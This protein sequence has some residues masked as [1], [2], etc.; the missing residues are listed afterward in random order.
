MK[1]FKIVDFYGGEFN[2][3]INGS[4]KFKSVVGGILS[5]ITVSILM[6]V[7]FDLGSDFIYRTNPYI[8][9]DDNLFV[10]FS[11]IT[12]ADYPNK[13]IFFEAPKY[14]KKLAVLWAFQTN[15][16]ESKTQILKLC[17]KDYLINNLKFY[18]ETEWEDN[19]NIYDFY[20]FNLNEFEIPTIVLGNNKPVTDITIMA[21]SCKDIESGYSM[22]SGHNM[23][24]TYCEKDSYNQ[25]IDYTFLTIYF[26]KLGFSA[27]ADDPFISKW[28][29]IGFI[30]NNDE[31]GDIKVPVNFYKLVDDRGWL[32]NNIKISNNLDFSN[33]R[34][35]TSKIQT[36]FDF[37]RFK[38][39]FSLSE[40]YKV[41]SRSYTKL[42]DFLAKIGGFMKLVLT[43]LSILNSIVSMYLIDDHI[44]EK[45][46]IK[47][48]LTDLRNEMRHKLKDEL[49]NTNLKFNNYFE[50]RNLI[51]QSGIENRIKLII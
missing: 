14:L 37:P 42:P 9:T 10:N 34:D 27:D 31:W 1:Y 30:F 4:S 12:G 41:Y 33:Y 32:T 8:K 19:L 26:Q 15:R 13:T 50:S 48:E 16:D 22:L 17:S 2:L 45:L 39:G 3:L 46:F 23:S 35:E 21:D 6:W 47:S 18:N 5:A 36:A 29:A 49:Q 11:S 38:I 44:N 51:Q 20:C 25:T 28:S 43:I 40:N 24:D 7:I